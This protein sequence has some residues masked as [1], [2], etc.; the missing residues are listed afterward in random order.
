MSLEFQLL[1]I[2]A[3]GDFHSGIELGESIGV[4]RTAIWKQ[5]QK[6]R[7]S[8]GLSFD[9]VKGKGYRLARPFELLDRELILAVIP[10]TI[11]SLLSALELHTQIDSTNR[12]A[13]SLAQAGAGSGHAVLAE[14]QLA[15]R[16]R[17]G[18]KWVSPF[19][20]NLY[21]SLIWVFE[22]GAAALEGL[23]LVVGVAVAHALQEL[24]ISD[25]QLKWPNDIYWQGRKLGGILLEMVGDATGYCQV[26]IGIGLNVDMSAEEASPIDQPW[27]DLFAARGRVISRNQLAGAVLSHLL[28]TLI[29]FESTGF[30]AFHA[31]WSALDFVAG[32]AVVLHVGERS[33]VGI[34]A[35]IGETGALAIDTEMGR[36]W[37]HGGEV[38][39]RLQQ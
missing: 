15:G 6:L 12:H 28:P 18:R 8:T 10:S 7:D 5:L 31:E 34:A 19:G 9:S 26:V 35:G 14:Q 30:S 4:S 24:G 1:S 20:K 23:S 29:K 39:L 22:N 33:L 21:L 37:F 36:E 17:R 16:G 3:D 11:S 38:S 27:S 2:L 32:R 25:V 13:M